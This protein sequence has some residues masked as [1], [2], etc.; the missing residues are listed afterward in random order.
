M[1]LKSEIGGQK[2]ALD[3]YLAKLN[4]LSAATG[5]LITQIQ[6][7]NKNEIACVD[8]WKFG[9]RKEKKDVILEFNSRLVKQLAQLQTQATAG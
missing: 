8:C 2:A 9:T 7:F 6:A 1:E 5:S 4:E 3:L